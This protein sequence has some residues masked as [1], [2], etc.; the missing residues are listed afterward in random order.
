MRGAWLLAQYRC[1]GCNMRGLA[2]DT[3]TEAGAWGRNMRGGLA[4]GTVQM[5]GNML[6]AG[7]NTWGQYDGCWHWYMGQL[8]AFFMW[9]YN[10]SYPFFSSIYLGRG[11]ASGGAIHV[12][13]L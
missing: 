1:W 4:A 7:T 11:W 8:G 9:H 12:T 6:G 2:A 5:G 3:G 13:V 10:G